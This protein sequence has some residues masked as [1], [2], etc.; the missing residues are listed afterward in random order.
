MSSPITFTYCSKWNHPIYDLVIER[1]TKVY[2][3]ETKREVQRILMYECRCN[4]RL[5]GPPSPLVTSGELR[6][7]GSIRLVSCIHWFE[8]GTGILRQVE[9]VPV[10]QNED[11]SDIRVVF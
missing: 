7:E 1:D 6:G 2:Y 10:N 11:G 9:P 4:E 8:W 3:E 5:K